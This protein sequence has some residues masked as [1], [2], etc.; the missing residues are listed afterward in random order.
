[1]YTCAWPRHSNAALPERLRPQDPTSKTEMRCIAKRCK[2]LCR[3]PCNVLVLVGKKT[4]TYNA[5]GIA[6]AEGFQPIQS[7]L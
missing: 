5:R 2:L 6:I 1:M 3:L 4:I 7:V